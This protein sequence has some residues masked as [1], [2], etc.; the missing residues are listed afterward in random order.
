MDFLYDQPISDL[1][2]NR[3]FL[4][5]Q[6]GLYPGG[7]NDMP[8][9]HRSLGMGL[10]SGIVPRDRFG[11]PSDDGLIVFVAIGMSNAGSYF[12]AFRERLQSLSDLDP[13]VRLVDA[14][15]EGPDILAMVSGDAPYWC[16]VRHRV[17]SEGGALPQV[18]A[19]WFMQAVLASNIRGDS[20]QDHIMA[21]EGNFL[22][23]L[24]SM[25]ASFPLLR[26]ICSAAREFGGYGAEVS[27][28]PEPYAWCTGWAWKRLIERQASGDPAL[29]PIGLEAIPWLGWSG[30]FWANGAHLRQDGLSWRFPEDFE[31]DGIHPSPRG[32]GKAASI[33]LDFYRNDPVNG[34]LWRSGSGQTS[35]TKKS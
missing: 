27:G 11:E 23:A 16:Y 10:A 35:L 14:T 19:A 28:N 9:A 25:K 24:R 4:G 15:L 22:S 6:G 32:A 18:Q 1:P 29:A 17:E 26:Q 2:G 7:T 31:E 12:R 13:C 34:W 20:P 3:H 8:L 30:Y 5:M 21:L 33:L